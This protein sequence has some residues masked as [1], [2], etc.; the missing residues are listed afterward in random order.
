MPIPPVINDRFYS[1]V[2]ILLTILAS[3]FL[4]EAGVMLLL[5][6]LPPLS[7]YET[8]LLDAALLT[9]ISFPLLYLFLFRPLQSHIRTRQRC[10]AEV[11]SINEELEERVRERTASLEEAYYRLQEES[12][13]RQRLEKRVLQQQKM[14]TIGN[15]AAS[16]AHDLNN[17]L[18]G[19]VGYP[20]LLLAELPAGRQRERLLRIKES[21]ERAAALVD[22]LL[23]LARR[24][25]ARRE[26]VDLNELVTGQLKSPVVEDLHRRFPDLA[27]ESSLEAELPHVL[28]SPAHLAKSIMN[29]VINA[30]EAMPGGGSIRIATGNLSL[31]RQREGYEP[32]APGDYVV[33]RVADQGV[34]IRPEDRAR[35][36][37]PFF[38]N[39]A[40]A[41][42]GTGLGMSVVWA[43]VKDHGGFID[44]RS[45]PGKGTVIELYLP[46]TRQDPDSEEP[47]QPFESCAGAPR[48]DHGRDGRLGDLQGDQAYPAGAEDGHR[49][50]LRRNRSGAGG[51]GP[52]RRAVSQE[53]LLPQKTRPRPAPG[54]GHGSGAARAGG[55]RLIVS[56]RERELS[57]EG[58]GEG[59][60]KA[61]GKEA[62]TRP[63]PQAA[64]FFFFLS[65]A[66]HHPHRARD[67]RTDIR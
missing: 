31:E 22:D 25:V 58:T 50:R 21:G 43:S 52:R 54:T 19:L 39:K 23:A 32:I 30:A 57:V 36:F 20:D 49:Q 46:L 11:R 40:M 13:E 55:L 66:V 4:A 24:S 5:P 59:A 37:E 44:L 33:L 51:A 16:V 7:F 2:R 15:V 17:I 45:T 35:I 18:S 29:L 28:G 61:P 26:V 10:E 34:G 65:D 62:S 6:I 47:P 42:S 41:R 9:G 1:P 53:A 64:L 38:T 48:Y 67:F 63:R 14:E 3:L 12:T 56:G 27:I 8:A 60:E